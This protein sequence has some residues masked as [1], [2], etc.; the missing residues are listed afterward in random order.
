MVGRRGAGRRG[1]G[2]LLVYLQK[3]DH[4]LSVHALSIGDWNKD[5]PGGRRMCRESMKRTGIVGKGWV[6]GDR[7]LAI[8]F[9][10]CKGEERDRDGEG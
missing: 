2:S 10:R 6:M 3:T 4:V 7:S 1:E 5:V 8:G 9:N